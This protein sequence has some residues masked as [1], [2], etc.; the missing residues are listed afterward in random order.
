MNNETQ[1]ALRRI[2]EIAEE[3]RLSVNEL[4]W[5]STKDTAY[6]K[7]RAVRQ[8]DYEAAAAH[9]RGLCLSIKAVAQKA[10]TT[11]ST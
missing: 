8:V 10:L 11:Q 6:T 7:P 5:W 2:C 3:A 1:D 9:T 4:E